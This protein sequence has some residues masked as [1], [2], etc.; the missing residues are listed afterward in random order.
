MTA[1]PFPRSATLAELLSARALRTPEDRL[2]IDVAGGLAI[3]AA[4]LW[5]LPPAWP[6]ILS[7]GA[8]WAMYGLWGI[9]ERRLRA[10]SWPAQPEHE[11]TW[12]TVRSFSALLGLVG[13]VFLLFS[14]LGVGLGPLVS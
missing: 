10:V 8:T 1:D 14:A 4:S 3:G 13:F 12:R 6:V 9:A 7:A 11:V 2:W 5:A